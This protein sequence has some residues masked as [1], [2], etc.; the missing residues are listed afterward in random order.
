M[1]VITRG[2]FQDWAVVPGKAEAVTLGVRVVMSVLCTMRKA[3]VYRLTF[4]PDTGWFRLAMRVTFPPVEG[5][6]KTTGVELATGVEVGE[7][8][9]VN[10]MVGLLVTVAVQVL[11]GVRVLVEV[12]V[13]VKL[14]VTVVVLVGV[15]VAWATAIS[16]PNTGMGL[17]TTGWP[18]VPLAPVTLKL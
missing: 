8:V 4:N 5:L 10:G 15:A 16:A 18:F 14:G 17:K 2:I 9:A 11:V 3:V 1:S 7:E 6:G 12:E 13:G